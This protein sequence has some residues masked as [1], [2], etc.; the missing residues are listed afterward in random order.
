MHSQL[1]GYVTFRKLIAEKTLERV[2]SIGLGAI[3]HF[4]CANALRHLGN[5]GRTNLLN[6]GILPVATVYSVFDNCLSSRYQLQA[7]ER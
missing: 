1:Y 3:D 2:I 6:I 4:A 7:V 5:P